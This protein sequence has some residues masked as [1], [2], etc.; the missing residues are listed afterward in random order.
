LL[1]WPVGRPVDCLL[2]CQSLVPLVGR[3]VGCSVR[4]SVVSLVD[5]FVGYLFVC[6]SVRLFVCFLCVCLLFG[7]LVVCLV[8]LLVSATRDII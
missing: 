1:G 4:R 7:W 6:L 2:V 3:L 5:Y 8:G